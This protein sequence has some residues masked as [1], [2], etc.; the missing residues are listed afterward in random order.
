MFTQ[1]SNVHFFQFLLGKDLICVVHTSNCKCLGSCEH[2]SVLMW[3]SSMW[4]LFNN[5]RK[6]PFVRLHWSRRIDWV[7]TQQAQKWSNY[8]C[9]RC[10]VATNDCFFSLML[11]AM[12]WIYKNIQYISNLC[13]NQILIRKTKVDKGAT[14]TK[15]IKIIIAHKVQ[16]S[17]PDLQG[18]CFCPWSTHNQEPITPRSSQ[19]KYFLKKLLKKG[20]MLVRALG[21]LLHF[22][23]CSGN[24]TIN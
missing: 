21:E 8:S 15:E 18:I 1:P 2:D 3:P 10:H 12:S 5:K 16:F 23:S 4:H 6:Q 14:V 11:M 17:E 24:Y 9:Y 13:W 20:H 7:R 22:P 19:R